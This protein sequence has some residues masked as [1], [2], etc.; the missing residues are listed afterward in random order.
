MITSHDLEY[1]GGMSFLQVLY[2]ALG[3][4]G[5]TTLKST[6]TAKH[7]KNRY[8][9]FLGFGCCYKSRHQLALSQW[10][11]LASYFI[12]ITVKPHLGYRNLEGL[13]SIFLSYPLMLSKIK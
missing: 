13:V 3:V 10:L 1:H 8:L 5:S 11:R 6:T 9:G 7:R 4:F 12:S 2:V